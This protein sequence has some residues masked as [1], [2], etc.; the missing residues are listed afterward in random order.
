MLRTFDSGSDVLCDH[1][2]SHLSTTMSSSMQH[3]TG[4][5]DVQCVK[6][7]TADKRRCEKAQEKGTVGGVDGGKDETENLESKC[8]HRGLSVS[9]PW[10]IVAA[11]AGWLNKIHMRC[12][13]WQGTTTP[14][15]RNPSYRSVYVDD[16]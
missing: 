4:G 14:G 13:A 11:V 12:M 7:T 16:S 3:L 10:C 8:H 6:N 9:E 1:S 5:G 15:E 2:H